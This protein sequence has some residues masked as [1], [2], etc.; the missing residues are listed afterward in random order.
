MNDVGDSRQKGFVVLLHASGVQ[1]LER[2]H[3]EKPIYLYRRIADANDWLQLFV[4]LPSRRVVE[5]LILRAKVGDGGQI[6]LETLPDREDKRL[7][8]S[9]ELSPQD[10]RVISDMYSSLLASLDCEAEEESVRPLSL[11][12]R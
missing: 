4:R 3:D 11:R 6:T 2:L 7:W 5:K 12:T 1:R 9:A 10:P 8:Q